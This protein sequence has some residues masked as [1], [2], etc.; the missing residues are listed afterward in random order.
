MVVNVTNEALFSCAATGLPAPAIDWQLDGMSVADIPEL[1]PRL[2]FSNTT[3][4]IELIPN[5]AIYHSE[6]TLI[7]SNTRGVDTN[8]YT[9][10]ATV[11]EIPAEYTV[12]FELFVQ[13]ESHTCHFSIL[14]TSSYRINTLTSLS[15]VP[16]LPS[17]NI[18]MLISLLQSSSHGCCSARNCDWQRNS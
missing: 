3:M 2:S 8:D 4:I 16:Y 14:N 7:I 1:S 6:R 13:G 15:H 17:F 10:I 11:S 12:D 5:G 9:C 18:W